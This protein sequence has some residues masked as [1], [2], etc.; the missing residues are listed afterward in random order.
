MEFR[1]YLQRLSG[2]ELTI[3]IE[4]DSE[5][6][7]DAEKWFQT[8]IEWD[9]ESDGDGEKWLQTMC[10][11]LGKNKRIPGIQLDLS[12]SPVT[13]AGL[14]HLAGLTQLQ[15]LDLRATGVTA[16]GRQYLAESNGKIQFL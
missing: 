14:V 2:A 12:S 16:A 15:S 1:Q 11:E 3:K 8:I 5:L 7:G 4:W 13:D 9:S 10:E 6:G